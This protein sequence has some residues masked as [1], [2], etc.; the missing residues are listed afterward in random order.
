[1]TEE[2]IKEKRI[3]KLDSLFLWVSS[4]S[5]ISLSVFTSLKMSLISSL[6]VL[7]LIGI[8]VLIG[9]VDGA[10]FS[11]SF[12]RRIG[13]W[14][15]LLLGLTFYIPIVV[16][17]FGEYT[18]SLLLQT[19]LGA[20]IPLIFI[21]GSF[22][23]IIPRIYENFQITLGIVTKQILKR[24]ALASIC[25]ASI[26]YLI[27]F[28]G[29]NL[30]N[31][32]FSIALLISF[33]V[34]FIIPLVRLEREIRGLL[35]IE[36]Y[37]DFVIIK[38]TSKR[39][40]Y[41]ISLT[42]LIIGFIAL[43]IVQF[44]SSHLSLQIAVAL[45]VLVVEFS[46]IS[47]T[48]S[49]YFSGKDVF[50][51][52]KDAK[53]K[54]SEDQLKAFKNLE[55]KTNLFVFPSEWDDV[56]ESTNK[57]DQP[58]KSGSRSSTKKGAPNNKKIIIATIIALIIGSAFF[59]YSLIVYYT[60]IRPQHVSSPITRYTEDPYSFLFFTSEDI[61]QNNSS[62]IMFWFDPILP[63]EEQ[64]HV[65]M[66]VHFFRPM[67]EVDD[68]NSTYFALQTFQNVSNI[69]VTVN[70]QKPNSYGGTVKNLSYSKRATSY[71]LID[72]PTQNFT[73]GGNIFVSLEFIWDGIFWRNSFYEYTMIISF[74]SGFPNFIGDVGLP[75][76]AINDNGLLLPDITKRASFSIAKT[77]GITISEA[78]PNPDNVG[79]SEG[80]TWY[81]WDLKKRSD[82]DRYAST[83]V[84][85]NM[86][87]DQSKRD[88]D[89]AWANFPLYLGI[90]LPIMVSSIIEL[91]KIKFSKT[92]FSAGRA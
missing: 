36:K 89:V 4:I 14:N 11:K 32:L 40:V 84:T 57:K 5:A 26:L 51:L 62:S 77:S 46:V 73:I 80:K 74:N 63:E 56:S 15:Y 35:Q 1:V 38:K 21:L 81:S 87:V 60:M 9:Y 53:D 78:I 50:S 27:A 68:E 91:L 82:R 28:A 12:T 10:I 31:D 54:L 70:G 66:D 43:G 64:T 47:I 92:V 30:K 29:Q 44:F 67:Y 48:I 22:Y 25:F 69:D 23:G 6:P 34:V 42:L 13:G 2:E 41:I 39:I 7:I 3:D 20:V 88:Y 75:E 61:I 71:I 76:E 59:S 49:L 65:R 90:G 83:G 16:I 79:F 24:N 45:I 17:Q 18:F 8:S 55:K 37:Q 58:K 85:I 72:I 52:S 19:I 86:V 33:F